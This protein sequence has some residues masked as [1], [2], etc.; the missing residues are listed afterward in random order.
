MKKNIFFALF[1]VCSIAFLTSS[2]FAWSLKSRLTQSKEFIRAKMIPQ[3]IRVLEEEINENPINAEAHF[4]LGICYIHQN[5]NQNADERFASAFGLNSKYGLKIAEIYLSAGNIYLSRGMTSRAIPKYEKAIFYNKALK[6]CIVEKCF[7]KM[8][9]WFNRAQLNINTARTCSDSADKLANFILRNNKSFKNKIKAE[10]IIYAQSCLQ[11][12]K[13]KSRKGQKPY[14]REANKYLTQKE[15]YTVIPPPSWKTVFEKE[16]VGVGFTGGKYKDGG[17][18]T[19]E[20][21]KDVLIG[22]R[23]I[24][25]GKGNE[26]IYNRGG[27]EK[28]QY[29]IINKAGVNGSFYIRTKKGE[30]FKVVIKRFM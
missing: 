24:V 16:F 9:F 30:K 18:A 7:D 19:V 11:T 13:T 4:Q 25:K 3:A 20:C 28:Y 27:W 10:Q 2:V 26:Q 12:A 29:P 8:L 23:I 5:A 17:V 14:L 1:V 22:D 21:G 6:Q 15:I